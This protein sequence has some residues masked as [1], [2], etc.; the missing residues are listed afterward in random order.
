M[1][2]CV[3]KKEDTYAFFNN[4]CIYVKRSSCITIILVLIHK[5]TK[6]YGIQHFLLDMSR[7]CF[8]STFSLVRKTQDKLR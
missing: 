4:L 5:N 2:F 1:F 6:Q 3:R 7:I 8:L